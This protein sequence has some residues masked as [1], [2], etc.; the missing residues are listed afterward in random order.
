MNPNDPGRRRIL[1]ILSKTGYIG[2]MIP[3]PCCSFTSDPKRMNIAS[4]NSKQFILILT[5]AFAAIFI[6]QHRGLNNG[7][8]N[9]PVNAVYS[10]AANCRIDLQLNGGTQG[11]LQYEFFPELHSPRWPTPIFPTI[12]H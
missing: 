3:D 2:F 8:T 10:S 6:S 7:F 1:W 11:V 9:T 5:S 4:G 12:W